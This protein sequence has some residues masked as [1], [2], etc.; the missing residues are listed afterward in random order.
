MRRLPLT[1]FI[2]QKQN[3]FSL[4]F[5]YFV[6]PHIDFNFFIALDWMK[7][8]SP[9]LL[10]G[11]LTSVLPTDAFVTG[12]GHQYRVYDL[13]LL[14]ACVC[15]CFDSH[16]EFCYNLGCTYSFC[17]QYPQ[18]VDVSK[19]P[20]WE[21]VPEMCSTPDITLG[22]TSHTDPNVLTVLIQNEIGGQ[23]QAKCGEDW[24]VVERFLV[25]R[26]E[27]NSG[28]WRWDWENGYYG[29]LISYSYINENTLFKMDSAND[30][31]V[32]SQD[33]DTSAYNSPYKSTISAIFLSC[34]TTATILAQK[35]FTFL[36]T[37]AATVSLMI[38]KGLD[39]PIV[40]KTSPAWVLFLKVAGG[41][42]SYQTA[43]IRTT[44]DNMVQLPNDC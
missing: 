27:M 41:R 36:A 13:R 12:V 31:E 17:V 14:L 35:L 33:D 7:G 39:Q 24:V 6:L 18:G 28:V 32:T 5:G 34:A 40:L 4:L 9:T 38:L 25:H 2:Y 23:L 29:S 37:S 43:S 8:S 26:E 20:K 10:I 21:P 15:S 3:I 22:I 30:M 42:V 19:G 44:L 1:Y 16:L 11:V